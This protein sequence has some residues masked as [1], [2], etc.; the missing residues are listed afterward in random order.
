[1]NAAADNDQDQSRLSKA[2]DEHAARRFEIM[3]P[4]PR[5]LVVLALLLVS[6]G[7]Y[8]M[9]G[10]E[11]YAWPALYY[12]GINGLIILLG[13]PPILYRALRQTFGEGR[14]TTDLLMAV[15]IVSAA[16]T[17]L[18]LEAALIVLIATVSEFLERAAH[19]KIGRETESFA[20]PGTKTV[21]LRR[22]GDTIDVP[23]DEVKVGQV[24]VVNDGETM[25]VDGVITFGNAQ[26]SE[27]AITGE[28]SFSPKAEG[29]KVFA[30]SVIQHGFIEVRMEKRGDKTLLAQVEQSVRKATRIRTD[31]E[32]L[33]DRIT[34]VLIP[35]IL[36]AGLAIFIFYYLTSADKTADDLRNALRIAMT[37]V[38]VASPAALVLAAPTAVWVGLRRAAHRGVLF[39]NGKILEQLARIRTLLID[40]TGTLTVARPTVAEVCG[41]GGVT[42][43]EVLEAALFVERHSDHPLAET[44]AAYGEGKVGPTEKPEKFFEFEGGGACGITG[45]RHIKVGAMWLMEDG[46]EFS[47]E[48]LKWIED[49]KNKGRTCVLVCDKTRVLGGISFEDAI[50]PEAKGVM[51]RLRKLGIKKMVML[52]GDN[53]KAAHQIAVD[54][55]MNEYVAECMP[56]TKLHRVKKEQNMTSGGVAMVGDGINDA[57][58]LAKADVGISMGAMGTDLA[59]AASQVTLLRDDLEGLYDAFA[60]SRRLVTSISV[61]IVIAIVLGLALVVLAAMGQINLLQGAILQ[62]L[63]ALII[64][65]NAGLFAR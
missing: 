63:I 20:I 5:L 55:G 54:M 32:I 12:I 15:V 16:A 8:F 37:V 61:N 26:V 43:Q 46:R 19:S 25:P 58:A 57:P 11:K 18:L 33:V 47:E 7:M 56:D 52:T 42:E 40:K 2:A 10:S 35:L 23:L 21:H 1:M 45:D 62:Q 64:T 48:T 50:R 27:A 49:S 4:R 28:S 51:E 59:V 41:F 60:V 6:G 22:E 65:I 29:D 34:A 17:T 39:R 53:A 44:I 30:G 9:L 3:G 14:L 38:V 36:A 31:T 13:F 24:L